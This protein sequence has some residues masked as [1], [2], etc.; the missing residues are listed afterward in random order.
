[1]STSAVSNLNAAGQS[2]TIGKVL[3][4]AFENAAFGVEVF[5]DGL[6]NSTGV[7]DVAKAAISGL[8]QVI[9]A[10]PIIAA[11]AAVGVLTIAFNGLYESAEEANEKMESSFE[12]YDD[13]RQQV[14]DTNTELENTKAKIDEL[15]AKDSLTF[16][17]ESELQRLKDVTEQLTLQ[18]DLKEKD[19]LRAGKQM[20]DDTLNAYNKN[21]KKGGFDQELYDFYWNN[22]SG[23]SPANL[24]VATGM[25]DN[26]LSQLLAGARLIRKQRNTAKLK[27]E[28]YEKDIASIPE[29]ELTSDQKWELESLR[30]EYELSKQ[31]YDDIVNNSEDSIWA[32]VSLL[33]TYKENLEAI[34]Y[35][36][37]SKE[38]K[39]ALDEINTSIESVYKE[40]EPGKWKQMQFDKI[41]DSAPLSKAKKEL[42]DMAIESGNLGVTVDDVKD[43]YPELAKAVEE[44]GF[45]VDDLVSNVNSEAGIKNVDEVTNQI[46]DA[47]AKD[48]ENQQIEVEAD[49]E[50][51]IEGEADVKVNAE[52]NK[53][54]IEE[55]NEFVDSLSDD[56][57]L[58]AFDIMNNQDTS[59]WSIEDWTNAINDAK[60]S[61]E[62]TTD[63]MTSL[64]LAMAGDFGENVNNAKEK[65]DTLKDALDKLHDGELSDSDIFELMEQF[66]ELTQYADDLGTGIFNMMSD[67][68]GSAEDGTGV[69]AL[70]DAKITELGENTEGAEALRVLRD[71]FI[72]LYESADQDFGL[73]SQTKNITTLLS[74]LTK[75]RSI[76]A[77]QTTGKSISIEDFN[78][79]ELKDYRSA[80]EY[81]NGTMQLNA[82]KVNEI[83]K[84]KAEEQIAIND[85][86]KAMAQAEYL[87]NAGQI[88]KLR[89]QLKTATGDS[90]DAIQAEIDSLLAE[91]S[92]ILDTCASYNLM[93]SSI[94]EATSAYQ[95]WLNS[96]NAAQKGDMFDSALS[97]FSKINDT[98]NK[99]DSDSYGRIGNEDYKAALEFVIPDSVDSDDEAAVN[100]YMDSIADLF[101]WDENGNRDG[102]NIDNFCQKA[103]DEG[104]MVLDEST[105]EYKILGAKTMQDFADGLGLSLPLVQ[106]MFG[107]ME[108]F[109]GEF[110]WADEGIKTIGDLGVAAFESAEALRDVKGNSDLKIVMD[111]SDFEDKELAVKTLDTT[112]QEMNDL[113]AKPSVDA[114]EIENANNIIQYCVAQKQLLN[115]PA[116]MKVDTSQVT[117][118]IGTALSLL[119]QFQTAQ[120]DVEMKAAIGADTSEAETEV[121]N[122]ATQIQSLS[123]EIKATLGINDTD[124]STITS[125]IEALTPEMMVKAG[126]DQSLVDAFTATSHDTQANV[127]YEVVDRKVQAYSAP[128]KEANINYKAVF[129]DVKAPD[130]HGK[131]YYERVF[132]NSVAQPA[133]S[134]N[135]TAHAKGTA[136]ASGNWGTAPGGKT[137]VG[138]LGREIV[139]DPH[140]GR[141]YTVGDSGAQFVDIPKNAIVFNHLQS[142]S[143]LENG[144]A[145]GR[146][147]ALVGGTAMVGGGISR[148]QAVKSSVG[149]SAPTRTSSGSSGSSSSGSSKSSSKSSSSSKSKDD[150]KEQ[151]D[152]IEIAISRAE[153]AIE[154]LKN[155]A[156]NAFD[157]FTNRNKALSEEVKKV[158]SEITLQQKAYKRYIK[159]ANSV[160]LSKSLKK[161]VKNG[162]I[163]I[164][165]YDDKTAE[166]IKQYQQWYEKALDCKD[167]I[168]QLKITVSE[169][170]Q[171]K[172][173]NTVTKWTNKTQ[174]LAHTAEQTQSAISRRTNA[175]EGNYANMNSASLSNITDYQALT[176]NAQSQ[177]SIKE[178]ERAA[179]NKLLNKGIKKGKIKKG[180]EEYYNMLGQIQD[181]DNEIDTLKS[182][183]VDFS[184]SISDEY[185]NMF[186]NISDEFEN[187]LS[188][189]ESL[190]DKYNTALETA[191]AQGY[192]ASGK[193]YELL[194][195]QEKSNLEM[196]KQEQQQLSDSLYSAIANNA[197]QIGT[198]DWYDMSKAI[199]DVTAEID[200]AN[201]AIIEFN[202]SIREVEWGRFDYLEDRIHGLADESNF[203]IDLLSNDKMF[204]DK[205][206]LTNEGLSVMGLHGLNY[207]TYMSQADDYAEQILAINKEIANDPYNTKLIERRDELIAKQQESI[208]AAEDEKQAIKDLVSEGIDAELDSL[209]ELIENYKSALDSA[210]DLH[211]YQKKVEEQ[212]KNIASL[213]KQLSAYENDMSEETRAK[214]QKLK[215]ELDEANEDMED[216]QYERYISDQEKLLDNLYDEYEKVLN[217]R[218]DNLDFLI[219]DMID[220]INMNADVINSTLK[221][222]AD[223]VGYTMTTEMQNI[224]GLAASQLAAD[225]AQRLTDATN[226]LNQLVANG[227]LSKADAQRIID[228]LGSGDQQGIQNALD[229]IAELTNNGSLS[230]ANAKSITD[231]LT[232]L[233]GEYTSVL[234][235]YSTNFDTKATALNAAVGSIKTATE[236]LWKA[237][238]EKAQAEA[239]AKAAEEEKK[240]QEQAAAAAAAAQAAAQAAA[241][242]QRK[243]QEQ[244]AAA[245]AAKQQEMQKLDKILST[246]TSRKKKLTKAEK[247]EHTDLW[248]HIVST[249][250]V[251]P[252]T[253]MY[254]KLAKLF[255]IKVG[256]KVSSKEKT[257]ILNAMKAKGYASGSEYIAHNQF[258]VTQERGTE[259]IV[260]PSEGSILYP[261]NGVSTFL[262]QGDAVLPADATDNIWKMA[263]NPGSFILD[264]LAK[265][266]SAIDF[267]PVGNAN[268]INQDIGGID[269]DINI[270]E[271]ADLNDLL[272][273]MQ[274]S[275]GFERLVQAIAVDPLL[276]KSVSEKRKIKF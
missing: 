141:W 130:L 85:T 86:N 26:D 1:M 200:N 223:S 256:D 106:A 36:E 8:W 194:R 221:N 61:A 123:P 232:K 148:K 209:K 5:K 201:K 112:I 3:S 237:A 238:D 156:T 245:A 69:L 127:V 100:S 154:R 49:A 108:E 198:K 11:V 109:G 271:V 105:D 226:L 258:A 104:L 132:N 34:P 147:T 75:A 155:T 197:I 68:M 250:G 17:E 146:A 60:V 21:F 122:L 205:G 37:L 219:S 175:A 51:E 140:T 244:A 195:D 242:A 48:I 54:S 241:E 181:I 12:A 210:K 73:S 239:A 84:A 9:S 177:I 248:E 207:N 260:R 76:L 125:S 163:N 45:T 217:E 95:H 129:P 116:V 208:Q 65:L 82:E 273:Q 119:Q 214:V 52:V 32:Q 2:L 118:D 6:A 70:F 111:V 135:G 178:Q 144:Y 174:N 180:S 24:L 46:K 30:E 259:F 120:N 41:F 145:V 269:L 274:K 171:E 235:A 29:E 99:T 83:V 261:Q 190:S 186:N 161:K 20:A 59:T 4:S 98:L 188:L 13:A 212:T 230:T 89:D 16:V 35:D 31:Y 149:S 170:F 27:L 162:T 50:G 56:D 185:V 172:F 169:L 187:K 101:T 137:L 184:N 58:I 215:V 193:Y 80:L 14:V 91:N 18:A 266:M 206:Q 102:L 225:R 97:A 23:S 272:V 202:N 222:A 143:L 151:I 103:V 216:A 233:P 133:I 267:A 131:M 142:E 275:K 179:L 71:A 110:T 160:G 42:V 157:T 22:G 213:Q 28:K 74:G 138:E 81:V 231:I 249:Y 234:S 192:A 270:D 114:S 168:Q 57:K 126:V 252:T 189:A 262:K 203:L 183:I 220:K 264:S 268:S 40:L 77:E 254:K 63:S 196:L 159:E 15:E 153:R 236:A 265:S 78:S 150:G 218:L 240:R 246:G 107:E 10:H 253:A 88:E 263:N 182:D 53:A 79:E 55:F 167:A 121:N 128:D 224:W 72:E 139:V 87:K 134:V 229:I 243:A 257:A 19:A 276:G 7:I 251:T 152:W 136:Y 94:N 124:V 199:C 25:Q 173:D 62:E 44:A 228:A 176:A 227:E 255:G 39:D 164:S 204:N 67:I 115:E 96:Q 158:T 66:P 38:Q 166:K 64:G 165:D 113:K 117:G 191:E 47:Y 247:K 43:K 92:T 33:Q 90:A 211:D 93:T